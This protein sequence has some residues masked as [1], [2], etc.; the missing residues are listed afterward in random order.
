MAD[1]LLRQFANHRLTLP[2]CTNYPLQD[3]LDSE[4]RCSAKMSGLLDCPKEIVDTIVNQAEPDHITSFAW[5]WKAIHRILV[6]DL[7]KHKKRM[8]N[9]N[10]HFGGPLEDALLFRDPLSVIQDV[11]RDPKLAFYPTRMTMTGTF[12]G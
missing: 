3:R 11:F 5:Y 12:S 7:S 1:I 2:H 8:D 4:Q 6:N 9:Y 10:V